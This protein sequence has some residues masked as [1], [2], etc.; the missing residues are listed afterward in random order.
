MIRAIFGLAV[1]V[2]VITF[3]M[4]GCTGRPEEAKLEKINIAFQEWIG[5]GLFYLAQEKEFFKEEG[6][7]LVFIDEQLD[8][9]RR[10]AFNQG[11][12]DCEAGTMDLLVTK[13]AQDTPVVAVMEIDHSVGSNGIVA[14]EDIKRVIETC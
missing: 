13:R 2:I 12:L 9:A 8:S 6:M 5:Y 3:L 10:D 7:E 1:V 14:T 11:M 4:A